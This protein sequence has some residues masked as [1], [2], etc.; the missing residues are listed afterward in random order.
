MKGIVV[1]ILC[2]MIFACTSK[3]AVAQNDTIPPVE[4]QDDAGFGGDEA[5]ESEKTAD[6]SSVKKQKG[7]RKTD[8][9]K[10]RQANPNYGF[11]SFLN[12]FSLTGT[13]GYG[14]TYYNPTDTSY[15]KFRGGGVPINLSLHFNF[16]ERFR[17]GGGASAEFHRLNQFDPSTENGVNK[18]GTTFTRFYGMFGA[19]VYD[20][21]SYSFVPEIQVGKV[22]LGSGFDKSVV[23]NSLYFNI[24]LS[25]E[26]NLSEYFRVIARPSYERKS[27]TAT[28]LSGTVK[29]KMPAVYLQIGVSINYP[30][31]PRCPINSCYTQIKHIHFGNEYRGQAIPIKQN[32][33]YGELRPRLLKYK[34]KNRK[35]IN[36]Y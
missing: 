8:Q 32:R 12:K 14:R 31:V 30:D 2:V 21:W 20:Y 7:K 22:N 35:K 19:K 9:I 5:T 4:E 1:I 25:I 23:S 11:R 6:T 29:Y 15:L 28:E 18:Q 33:K 34:R 26:K 24:G 27:Y 16:L 10:K 13:L 3:L 36:P 17:L